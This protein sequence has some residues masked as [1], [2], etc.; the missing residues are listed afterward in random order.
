[1]DARQ[2]GNRRDAEQ[3][4]ELHAQHVHQRGVVACE[5][6]GPERAPHERIDTIKA[7]VYGIPLI[8]PCE[9]PDETCCTSVGTETGNLLLEPA[10]AVNDVLCPCLAA[11]G[12]RVPGAEVRVVVAVRQEVAE[13][14]ERH[15]RVLD[16]VGDDAG[17]VAEDAEAVLLAEDPLRL[18]TRSWSRAFTSACAACSARSLP[19]SRSFAEKRFG[20]DRS[21]SARTP[22]VRLSPRI[23]STVK[24]GV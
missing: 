21:A 19:F 20:F 7:Q 22:S 18:Q 24:L 5:Q 15:E 4:P 3:I 6:V 23:W 10:Q 16:L 17:E 12:V 1:M 11:D 14:S 9:P 2:L 13:R 8:R